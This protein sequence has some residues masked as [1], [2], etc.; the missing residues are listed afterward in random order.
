MGF[1]TQRRSHHVTQRARR[2]H[3]S[4]TLKLLGGILAVWFICSFGAGILFADALEHIS[5]AA[6]RS[7]SGSRIR[8]SIYIFIALIFFYAKAMGDL[9]RKFDVLKTKEPALMDLQTTTYL[10]VGAS[11]ALYIGIAIWARAGS[12]SEFYAAGGQVAPGHERDGDGG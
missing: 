6:I 12:T 7:A 11:F 8:G 10:V 5:S 3:W 2:N 1:P 9:D 4:A